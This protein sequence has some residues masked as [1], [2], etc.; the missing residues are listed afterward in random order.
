LSDRSLDEA[1][2]LA[3]EIL[4][5]TTALIDCP[6]KRPFY[7]RYGVPYYWIMDPESHPI[8]E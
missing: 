6:A 7:A 4:S 8:E 2:T 5:P 3:V 1:L